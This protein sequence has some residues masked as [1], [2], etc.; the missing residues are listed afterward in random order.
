M[1][2]LQPAGH[3]GIVQGEGNG[4]SGRVAEAIDVDHHFVLGHP[5]ALGGRHDDAA[6]G[7]MG[8]EEVEV[9][10]GEVVAFEQTLA[11]LSGVADGELVDGLAVLLRSEERRVGKECRL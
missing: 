9:L 8:D 5:D 7:L 6:V 4:G 2:L 11:D 1:T 10:A 3:D